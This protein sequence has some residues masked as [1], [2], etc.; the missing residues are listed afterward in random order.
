[1]RTGAK[2]PLVSVPVVRSGV[3]A[4]LLVSFHELIQIIHPHTASNNLANVGHQDVDSL[5]KATV[6]L[7]LLH[8]ECFDI[9]WEP[10]EHDGL[11][12]GVSHEP[13]RSFWDVF[14]NFI[15]STIFL[16]I[17][18]ILQPLNSLSILHSPEWL[19]RRNKRWVQLID[20]VTQGRLES[21]VHHITD[22][23]FETV[24]QLIEVNK[25]TL[26]LNMTILSNMTP[27]S[28]FL[29]SGNK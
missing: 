10:V 16:L 1:M 18:M 25:W 26:G 11:I 2:L 3:Q 6:I 22:Q 28:R 4:F 13:F 5:G 20:Q 24:K 29:S 14:P 17:V 12:D 15:V 19:L 9:S 21:P 7:A 23:V 8:V 27:G